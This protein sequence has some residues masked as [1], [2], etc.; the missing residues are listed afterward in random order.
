V[1]KSLPYS[2]RW[3]KP[4][5]LDDSRRT[6]RRRSA[7]FSVS[8]SKPNTNPHASTIIFLGDIQE[9]A[10]CARPGHLT[11][12]DSSGSWRHSGN[13]A[14]GMGIDVETSA[15]DEAHQRDADFIGKLD[16]QRGWRRYRG[17][18]RNSRDRFLNASCS[19]TPNFTLFEPALP[20][21]ITMEAY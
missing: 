8:G 5:A 16:R 13:Y 10:G 11:F 14:I 6:R 2:D 1:Y 3:P 4:A 19:A 20:V 7:I 9:R 12:P 15:A 17:H 21:Y 18:D